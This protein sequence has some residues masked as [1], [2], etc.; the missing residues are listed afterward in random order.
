MGIDWILSVF[1]AVRSDAG[2]TNDG[3]A[4]VRPLKGICP[5]AAPFNVKLAMWSGVETGDVVLYSRAE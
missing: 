2:T 5:R 4:P 3:H 1:E